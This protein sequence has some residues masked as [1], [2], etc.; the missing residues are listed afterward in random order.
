[1]APAVPEER[2]TGRQLA[3]CSPR[4]DCDGG[5]WH[6][7][8]QRRAECSTGFRTLFITARKTSERLQTVLQEK[9]LCVNKVNFPDF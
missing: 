2:N 6:C 7:V 9:S 3:T 5:A 1:M 4:R 8:S